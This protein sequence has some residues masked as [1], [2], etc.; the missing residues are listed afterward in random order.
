MDANIKNFEAYGQLPAIIWNDETVT[1][2]ELIERYNQAVSF[3]T[4]HNINK[5]Q[6]ISL[7]GDFTPNSIALMFALINNE[8]IIV[9]F[10]YSTKESELVK[11]DIA[12]VQKGLFIDAVTDTYRLEGKGGKGEHDFYD[13]VRGRNHPGL[14]LFTSGTSGKPKGAVHDFSK[15]LI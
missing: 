15:L 14:V 13:I 5:G 7:T 1:Y 9:P 2:N 3:I 4:E 8:N 12:D 11:Y 6:V 10:T